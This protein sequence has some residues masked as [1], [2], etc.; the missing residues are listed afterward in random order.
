MITDLH[1]YAHINARIR[2]MLGNLLSPAQWNAFY[3]ASSLTD[4]F[5]RLAGTR[6]E[7]W[8]KDTSPQQFIDSLDTHIVETCIAEERRIAALLNG[9]P[10]EIVRIFTEYYDIEHIKRGLRAWLGNYEFI[11]PTISQISQQNKIPWDI[12]TNQKNSV[13]DIILSLMNTPYGKALSHGRDQYKKT[14]NL[15]FL[16]IALEKD[17]FSRI[18]KKIDDL[19]GSDKKGVKKLIGIYL[20]TLNIQNLIRCKHYF[21]LPANQMSDLIY[22]DGAIFSAE[23]C[24]DCYVSKDDREFLSRLAVSPFEKLSSF[25]P[26]GDIAKAAELLDEILQ[27]ILFSQIRAVLGGYPFTLGVV[28]S[29]I[30]LNRW[31]LNNLRSLMWTLHLG[32]TNLLDDV[33]RHN[34][35]ASAKENR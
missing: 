31:E 16:E 1:R 30:L 32:K 5:A 22:A 27:H 35:L 10:A 15:F 20:D 29:Y 7:P 34:P 8:T 19:S 4:A 24:F 21:K 33:R 18:T 6:Y 11:T 13:E 25:A 14:K 23:R 2:V 17:F 26:T 12:F 28:L 9:V 3:H